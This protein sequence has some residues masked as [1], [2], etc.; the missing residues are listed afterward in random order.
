MPEDVGNEFQLAVALKQDNNGWIF[1][2]SPYEL[3]WLGES[4]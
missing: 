4:Q 2:W 3:A 1:V